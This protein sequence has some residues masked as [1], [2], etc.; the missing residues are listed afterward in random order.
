ML[1]RL[2]GLAGTLLLVLPG[3]A[4]AWG[5]STHVFLASGVLSNLSALPI[6]VRDLLAAYPYE[7]LYGNL[8]ADIT[9]AK[10]YVRYGRHCHRWDVGFFL[11]GRADTERL[12]S[13]ALGYLTHL[14]ADTLAHNYFVPRQLLLTSSTRQLGHA[15]WEFR[16]DAHLPPEHLKLARDLVGQDHSVPDALLENVLTQ[17]ILSFRMNKEIFRRMI[18][19]SNDERWQSLFERV[20]AQSRWDL[21]D[22]EVARW[23]EAS[24]HVVGAFLSHGA[25]SHACSLDPIGTENLMLAKKVRRRTIRDARLDSG[26]LLDLRK[27]PEQVA[28]MAEIFF[29]L[30]GVPLDVE[31]AATPDA[32]RH[33]DERQRENG[34]A[35]IEAAS[36]EAFWERFKGRLALD[37]TA[38]R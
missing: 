5:P 34:G 19:L 20:V 7:F 17:A 27:H 21:S 29:P 37:L 30:P 6:A 25:A 22:T 13:F 33:P 10:K 12:R 35:G 3:D 26:R 28:E 16:F 36:D 38:S 4:W 24:R 9:L 1:L 31:S 2:L 8:S 15:Y 18:H 11:L 14:A 32:G 23:V